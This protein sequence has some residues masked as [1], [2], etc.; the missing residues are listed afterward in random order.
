MTC[1]SV[2]AKDVL[3]DEASSSF[4]HRDFANVG[5]NADRGGDGACAG[6]L[7]IIDD[8]DAIIGDDDDVTGSSSVGSNLE[9]EQLRALNAIV[10]LVDD[11]TGRASRRCFVLGICRSSLSRLPP[12]LAR[13]GR[14]EKEIVMSPPTLAQRRDIF[15][16]WLSTLPLLDDGADGDM[17]VARW[18]D[19]LAPRTAGCVAADIRRICADALTSAASRV[20]RTASINDS[21]VTWEDV[22]ESARTCVPSELSSLDVIPASLADCLGHDTLLD[23]KRGFESAWENFGG[24]DYEKKRLYRT[25]FRPWKHHILECT[26]LSGRLNN[27]AQSSAVGTTLGLSKPSGVLFHGPSG[28]GKSMAALCLASSLGLH[29]VKVSDM[30]HAGSRYF[31]IIFCAVLTS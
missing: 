30:P 17:T 22:K 29:C 12:Q 20:P 27:D 9:S 5:G 6:L 14:F 21:T 18:A 31:C 13:V 15:R 1:L 2:S 4:D 8:L 26:S 25:V 7:L 3:L 28:C 23:A 10:K 16:F 19:S 11:A 24:Y